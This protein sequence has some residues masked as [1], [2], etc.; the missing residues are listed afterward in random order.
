MLKYFLNLFPYTHLDAWVFI[1]HQQQIVELNHRNMFTLIDKLMYVVSLPFAA[2]PFSV[3]AASGHLTH[4]SIS[5]PQLPISRWPLAS[6]FLRR[7]HPDVVKQILWDVLSVICSVWEFNPPPG[8]QGP[9]RSVSNQA[10][11]FAVRLLSSTLS[12]KDIRL[13]RSEKC[14]A[15]TPTWEVFFL[16]CFFYDAE[17]TTFIL[18]FPLFDGTQNIASGQNMFSFVYPLIQGILIILLQYELSKKKKHVEL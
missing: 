18:F 7:R 13:W 10:G 11:F 14:P 4:P 17:K 15:S 1:P 5:L 2:H 16:S 8:K 9:R 12:F 3:L 6:P